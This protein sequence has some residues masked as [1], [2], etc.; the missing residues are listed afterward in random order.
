MSV[1]NT[2]W[3]ESD[4]AA[5]ATVPTCPRPITVSFNSLLFR[6]THNFHLTITTDP[7]QVISGELELLRAFDEHQPADSRLASP[8]P[9]ARAAAADW[10]GG[11]QQCGAGDGSAVLCYHKSIIPYITKDA[12]TMK[13]ISVAVDD[14]I[15]R[16]ARIKAAQKSTSMSAMLRDYL[17]QIL[18]EDGDQPPEESEPQRRARMLDEVMARFEAEGVGLSASERLNREEL[19]DRHASC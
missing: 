14:E 1:A 4:G 11:H 8:L 5:A 16:L 13:V 12:E 6:P 10:G 19:Y 17:L 9:Q 3:P 7:G 18:K 2:S 15:H